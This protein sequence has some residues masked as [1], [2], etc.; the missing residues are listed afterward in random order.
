MGDRKRL[1]GHAADVAPVLLGARLMAGGVTVRLTEVEA[2]GGGQDPASHAYR[3]RTRRTEVM[4]GPAGWAYVYLVYGMHWCLNVVVGEQGGAAAVLL[5]A[6]EVI[7]GLPAAQ[8]RRP[9][10]RARE[11]CRGPGRLCRALGI[12]GEHGGLDL[13]EA[14]SPVRLELCARPPGTVDSGPRVGVAGPGADTPWRFWIPGEP[15]VS[16]YRPGA[17]RSPGAGT[18]GSR[19]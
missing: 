2:Y 1:S 7:A 10:A 9:G 5:R 12:T 11:L 4:F 6:G 14:S 13:L 15:T 8:E 3:G 17:R 16:A 18:Q 19:A